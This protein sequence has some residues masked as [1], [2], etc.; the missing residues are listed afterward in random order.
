MK[1]GIVIVAVPTRHIDLQISEGKNRCSRPFH[2]AKIHD[3]IC[4]LISLVPQAVGT[5]ALG[6]VAAQWG[7]SI[8]GRKSPE[9]SL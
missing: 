2:N 4:G 8:G 1:T 6:R 7:F 3:R 5:V 9:Q